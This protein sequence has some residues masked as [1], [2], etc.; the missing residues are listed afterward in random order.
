MP[1]YGN[2]SNTL[3]LYVL[4]NAC[5]WHYSNT[6][7]LCSVTE[8]FLLGFQVPHTSR[9]ILFSS[10]LAAYI[11]TLTGN[12]MIIM[13]VSTTRHLHSPM[14]FFLSHLSFC[15]I[16]LSSSV[17]PNLLQITLH[18]GGRLTVT[19]CLIQINFFGYSTTTECLL[20]T[21]MSYDRY[22]AICKP[23]HY[24]TIMVFPFCLFLV[25]LSWIG[26]LVLTLISTGLLIHLDFCYSGDID[27]FF[28]DYSP[29]VQLS[30]SD[31]TV[32]QI[33]VLI[34]GTPEVIIETT[35]IITTYVCIFLA[36]H[37]ISTTTGKQK[38]FSTCSSHLAV[39]C[40]YYGTITAIYIF[41]SA[42]HSFSMSKIASLVYTVVTPFLNPLIYSLRNQDIKNS[43]KAYWKKYKTKLL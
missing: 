3:Y 18:N 40:M 23:L 38:A 26:G 41:S 42:E 4:H 9:I 12:I 15:N 21:V 36:I 2:Y 10:F 6:L 25:I 22:V 13:L 30:C 14:Y 32:V 43:I 16:M 7:Y 27:H 17:A 1:V 8:F 20:L 39:V 19:Q 37:R 29:L 11:L 34:V 31:T 5:V 24:Q 28:C 33:V 35:F